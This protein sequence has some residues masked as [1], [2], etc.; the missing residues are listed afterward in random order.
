MT[1]YV[2]VAKTS[3]IPDQSAKCVQAEG[4]KIALF[5][6]GGKFYALEDDCPHEHAPLSDG[7]ID[8]GEVECPW[9]GSRFNLKTGKVTMDPAEEDVRSYPVRVAGDSIEVEM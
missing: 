2:A 4:R 6:V 8:G 1:K 9:H 5:N 3:E 7:D